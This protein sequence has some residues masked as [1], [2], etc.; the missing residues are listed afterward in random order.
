MVCKGCGAE[1]ADTAKFCNEC[2]I[3]LSEESTYWEK[4]REEIEAE[5]W[6][7][8]MENISACVWTVIVFVILVVHIYLA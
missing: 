5:I 8:R 7:M 1:N 4:V 3:K 6:N 2:G